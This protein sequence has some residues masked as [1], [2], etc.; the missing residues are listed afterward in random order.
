MLNSCKNGGNCVDRS[1]G[2]CSCK[3]GFAGTTCEECAYGYFYYVV[4]NNVYC[5]GISN[6]NNFS[7]SEIAVFKNAYLLYNFFMKPF[8]L[9]IAF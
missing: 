6:N 3:N 9:I 2:K 4:N 7:D 8:Q 1:T 5:K